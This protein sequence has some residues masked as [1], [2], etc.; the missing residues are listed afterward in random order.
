MAI[1]KGTSLKD[2]IIGTNAADQLF[3]LGGDDLL[4]GKGGKDIL[5]GGAGNDTLDGGKGDDKLFGGAGKDMLIGGLGDD[6]LNGGTGDDTFTSG[7]GADKFIGGAGID[8]V[9][10]SHAG[11]AQGIHVALDNS[12]ASAKTSLGDTFSGVENVIG[13]DFFDFV[14]GTDLA[15]VL[16][17]GLGN[18]ILSGLSGADTL[19]GGEGDDILRPGNDTAVD[20]VNGGDG[21]DVVDYRDMSTGV[22]VDLI[23]NTTG[24][25]AAAD[26]LSS[27]EWVFGST[28][29]DVLTVDTSGWANGD[30]GND[31][32]SGSTT[33]A[34]TNEVLI[35]GNGNDKF[36]I[37]EGFGIDLILDF[38]SG[39]DKLVVSAAE[40]FGVSYNSMVV[41][42]IVHNVT[43]GVLATTFGASPQFI[44]D[45]STATLYYDPDGSGNTGPVPLATLFSMHNLPLNNGIGSFGDFLIV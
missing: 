27:I 41:N 11:G 45:E 2:K 43:N 12:E 22:I 1:K 23:T 21:A 24:G 29:D 13:T 42:N 4:F 31:T 36:V 6:V 30:D 32:I 10:Y 38:K 15:N 25:G 44:F 39:E 35:G 5:Y 34:P 20:H 18:D 8:T 3:G 19:N 17:G 7:L 16:S 26:V 28:H 14:I 40:F 9:D 33:G 37:D